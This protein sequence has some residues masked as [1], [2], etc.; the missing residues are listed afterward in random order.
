[1]K[2]YGTQSNGRGDQFHPDSPMSHG[3]GT[4]WMH[5]DPGVAYQINPLRVIRRRW[6][7][8]ALITILVAGLAVGLT[9]LETP[10]YT[11][12]TKI[13]IEQK[14]K[15]SGSPADIVGLQNLTATMAELV[16]TRTVAQGVI[17][18]LNLSMGTY[19]ILS[20]LSAQQVNSTQ[21]IEVSY[22]GSNPREVQQI[23]NAVGTVFSQ[24]VS[25]GKLG[26]DAAD[27]TV[28]ETA[29]LPTTP[30]NPNPK[31]D[32]PLGVAIGLMLGVGLAFLLEYRNDGWRSSEEVEQVLGVPAFGIIPAFKVRKPKRKEKA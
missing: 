16:N 10:H 24:Q 26:G 20:N 6:W 3:Y 27:A 11:A 7:I 5:D 22:T 13:L 1:M 31:L 29:V 28:Q 14:G 2:L 19:S 23:T 30:V 8:I 32:I 18:K 4:G 25:G 15:A 12:S 21:L 9:K 17:K